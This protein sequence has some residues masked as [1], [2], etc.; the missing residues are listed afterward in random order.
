MDKVSSE[1]RA[2]I[3]TRTVSG[4]RTQRVG[5][6]L[7]CIDAGPVVASVSFMPLSGGAE[8]VELRLD[9]PTGRESSFFTRFPL[10]D[11]SRAR[12]LF[13]EMSHALEA[14]LERG[15]ARVLVC[16]APGEDVGPFVDSLNEFASQLPIAYEFCALPANDAQQGQTDCV[17][18]MLTPLVSHLQAQLY[19]LRPEAATFSLPPAAYALNDARLVI[20][21]LL[22]AL[23][24]VDTP[25]CYS[26]CKRSVRPFPGTGCVLVAN[27][28]YCDRCVRMGYR[29]YRDDEVLVRGIVCK[30]RLDQRDVHDLLATLE[31][32]GVCASQ[33]DAMGFVTPGVVNDYSSNLPSMGLRDADLALAFT[34]SYGIPT[35]LDNNVN[36]AAMGCY[37]LQTEHEDVTLYRHQLGHKNGGQGTVVDGRLVR[38]HSNM[39]GEPK[40]Y[41]RLFCYEGGPIAATWHLDGLSHI[42]RNV[43]LA[44][45]GT[46]SPG[47]ACLAVAGA[48]DIDGIR[49][50]LERALPQYCVPELVEVHDYRDRMY[51]GEAALCLA[52]IRE[53]N[54]G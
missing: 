28:A 22:E 37:L 54:L 3:D 31:L 41:Q 10:E 2:W 38:G 19:E 39:A 42:A 12:E 8:A 48:G 33:L 43:L 51:L 29:V 30:S 24:E 36:A 52:R 49:R 14:E 1:F 5:C 18:R 34:E 20:Q 50:E 21:L 16:H 11:G 44:T 9:R 35:F 26:A 46:V 47:L 7:W 45:I 40:F 25:L 23:Y 32:T 4:H 13:D 53:Q 17:A 6:D 15:V 27:V